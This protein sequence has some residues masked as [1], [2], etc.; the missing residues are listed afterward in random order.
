MGRTLGVPVDRAGRVLVRP[1][2]SIPGHPEVFVVGDLAYLEERGKPIPGVAPAAMQMGRYVARVIQRELEGK[3]HEPFHYRDKGSLAVIGRAAAV[4]DIAGLKL[5]G[6]IAWFVWLFVH[7]MYLSGFRNRLVV[8]VQWAWA[9]VFWQ[10]GVRL[11]TGEPALELEQA[12]AGGE[13]ASVTGEKT[14]AAPRDWARR[15]RA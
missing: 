13:A 9:Y 8:L 5:S 3:M 15:R 6:F 12:R 7:I 4:A 14:S 11:I 2:C 1:D 10:R